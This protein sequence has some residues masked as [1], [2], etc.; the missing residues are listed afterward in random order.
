MPTALRPRYP[1][2]R[3]TVLP[4][5]FNRLAALLEARDKA[6][7]KFPASSGWATSNVTTDRALDADAT[8]LAEVADVLCT[9]IED[10]K[11]IGVLG[12]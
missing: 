2:A 10:L 3:D 6:A 12:K 8:T 5:T 1:R 9:L 7:V 4:D 11:T